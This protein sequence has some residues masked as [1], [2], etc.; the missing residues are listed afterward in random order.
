MIVSFNVQGTDF[1]QGHTTTRSTHLMEQYTH[2]IILNLIAWQ[3]AVEIGGI[4]EILSS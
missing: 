4:T 3:F 2:T 1:D